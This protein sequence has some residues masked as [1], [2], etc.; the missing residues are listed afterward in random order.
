[1]TNEYT[2]KVF[3][4]C[5]CGQPVKKHRDGS[6][7]S[8]LVGHNPSNT[9][10][11]E[12]SNNGNSGRFQPGNKCGKGRPQGSRNKATV[13]AANIFENEA[14]TIAR[15]AVDM[16]L[17]GNTAM[18]KLIVERILPVKRSV[19]VKLP[20]MPTVTSIADASELTGYVLDAVAK[21]DLSP[22]D[23]EIVSRSCERHL[24]ALQVS[25][26]EPRLAVL[27]SKLKG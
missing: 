21:G 11:T 17:E 5:G 2:E 25:D 15:H 20:D 14:G 12:P 23:A 7:P 9:G 19:P 24:R 6:F 8:F 27:E 16:A 18:V 13:A 22:V 4:A 3:C 26:L 1:M 10:T